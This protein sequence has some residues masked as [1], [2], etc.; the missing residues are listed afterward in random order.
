MTMPSI[1][2]A[3]PCV[4]TALFGTVT[5][6]DDNGTIRSFPPFAAD[7]SE[8]GWTFNMVRAVNGRD[9]REHFWEMHPTS[10]KFVAVASGSVNLHLRAHDGHPRRT[11]PLGPGTAVTVPAGRWH[12][13][14]VAEPSSVLTLARPTGTL[15]EPVAF[16]V[17]TA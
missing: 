10:D 9:F 5:C 15:L 6:L 11:F 2:T 4:P 12:L 17:A 14:E 13:L 7:S 8:D 1:G 3:A 16:D